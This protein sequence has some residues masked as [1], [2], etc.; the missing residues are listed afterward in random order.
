VALRLIEVIAPENRQQEILDVLKKQP[1]LG[2]WDER[3]SQKRVRVNL[4]VD[5]ENVEKSLDL[6]NHH[7]RSVDGF[8]TILLDVEAT[9]PRPEE[10]EKTETAR[11]AT[12]AKGKPKPRISREELYAD[13]LDST[14]L[15]WV[16]IVTVIL[17][18]IVAA[19]GILNN[20]IAIV[21]GAMV[22]APLLG[23]NVAL[24]LATTLG[25]IPLA[26]NAAKTNII[27]IATAL[28]FSVILGFI[29]RSSPD[30]PTIAAA[31]E[32]RLDSII[33]ALASG[34]AGALAFTTGLSTILI[35]VMVAVALLPPL[36]TFGLL[37][38]AGY[39]DP[40]LLAL[41]LF[42][43]NIICINLTGVVTFLIQGI[44]PATWWEAKKARVSIRNAI[45][46]WL[47]SLILLIVLTI[48]WHKIFTGS[49]S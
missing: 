1:S 25:D 23:P 33:L 21:I 40:A 32:V 7:F 20:N 34:S 42:L 26:R 30:I 49:A 8:R 2:C 31:T 37:L 18:S 22:I 16:Y 27:G 14:K 48:F 28:G 11:S 9:L 3:L 46:F 24:A 10:P 5:A 13:I 45:I 41:Q 15:S 6:L 38:G 4:L 44:R 17:S 12:K 43:I 35:G 47:L 39:W 36:V 19:I 29:V